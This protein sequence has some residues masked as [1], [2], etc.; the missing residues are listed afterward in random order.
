MVA[1]V[2]QQ[3]IS[4]KRVPNGFQ[5]RSLPHYPKNAKDAPSKGFVANSF[6]TGLS[7]SEFLFHACSGREGLVDTAVK[8]AETG[9]MQRRLMKVRFL[10]LE[11]KTQAYASVRQWRICLCDTTRLSET[12]QTVSF[13]SHLET[14]VLIRPSWKVKRVQSISFVHGNTSG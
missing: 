6:Y 9:Y 4:G 11:L 1:C 10:P 3:I 2:G 12:L 13:N 14:M 7:P 8:T 5:E